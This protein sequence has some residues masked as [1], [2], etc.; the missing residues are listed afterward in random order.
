MIAPVVSNTQ[1]SKALAMDGMTTGGS[2]QTNAAAAAAGV[3]QAETSSSRHQ[4]PLGDKS[5]INWSS[6]ESASADQTK[7]KTGAGRSESSSHAAR[8]TIEA[9]TSKVTS[10]GSKS[11]VA[12]GPALREK[13]GAA[14]DAAR[15]KLVRETSIHNMDVIE[16]KDME[17]APAPPRPPPPAHR[18]TAYIQGGEKDL[19]V[20][21]PRGSLVRNKVT[22]NNGRPGSARQWSPGPQAQARDASTIKEARTA[23]MQKEVTKPVT[24]PSTTATKTHVDLDQFDPLVTGQLV[25][26]VPETP[27]GHASLNS[28]SDHDDNLLKEWNLHFYNKGTT[29]AAGA[30]A[31]PIPPKM[32]SSSVGNYVPRPRREPPLPPGQQPTMGGFTS[33]S[34]MPNSFQQPTR[35]QGPIIVGMNNAG[36]PMT[37][38]QY[39]WSAPPP[40]A[41]G[42]PAHILHKRNQSPGVQALIKQFS[43]ESQE[44]LMSQSQGAM[45]ELFDA[46]IAAQQVPR[47]MPRDRP[48][49]IH[50]DSAQN[51]FG[52]IESTNVSDL[53][54]S[55]S[56]PRRGV[57][58][59]QG[60]HRTG[61]GEVAQRNNWE[62]FDS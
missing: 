50:V 17:L 28:V 27:S 12:A 45:P 48:V 44:L 33:Y 11:S 41:P 62:L 7:T 16:S 31:P 61:L 38:P 32:I 26:D 9:I 24:I 29:A 4:P 21:K 20:P 57:D 53:S 46:N 39:S 8:E 55:M 40:P 14:E 30:A 6:E 47:P 13:T 2:L 23:F 1:M 52:D 56:L 19:P 59:L 35:T 43:T 49:S 51:P 22:Y 18:Q 15:K 54:K 42:S 58:S 5:L 60:T 10:G 37:A 3:K 36:R 25:V 34:N